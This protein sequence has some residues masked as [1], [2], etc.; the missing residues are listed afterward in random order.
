MPPHSDASAFVAAAP[1]LLASGFSPIPIVPGDKIP[2]IISEGQWR[3]HRGWN[4]YCAKQPGS[5]Q[6]GVWSKWDR[7]GIGAALGRGLLAVDIDRD[8]L[9]EPIL[10]VLPPVV[11]AKRGRKGLTVFYRGDTDTL[12]SRGFK[13]D[14]HGIL[15]FL[16]HGKQTVLPP[17]LHPADI[18]YEWTT[19]RTLL[20]IRGALR[21]M[22]M[23]AVWRHIS[24]S[25]ATVS[26]MRA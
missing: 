6:V 19:A 16:S 2:G 21:P 26:S 14:G 9:V 25:P 1:G 3:F 13:I 20:D 24:R 4:Q 8:D 15:D 23:H 11:V 17:S 22:M 10:A 7:A 5:F 12:R 18:Q